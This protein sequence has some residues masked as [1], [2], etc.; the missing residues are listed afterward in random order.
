MV[1]RHHEGTFEK[2]LIAQCIS[3]SSV[4]GMRRWRSSLGDVGNF[5]SLADVGVGIRVLTVKRS[6]HPPNCLVNPVSRF[7][8]VRPGV[9]V[10]SLMCG[11]VPTEGLQSACGCD[12]GEY[13]VVNVEVLL[14][15][16]L[17]E[18]ELSSVSAGYAAVA[19]LP[20]ANRRRNK[21]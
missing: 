19:G 13:E 3:I 6:L 18:A 16:T 17:Q 21:L 5:C 15:G 7:L 14:T 11:E 9:Y 4:V 1:R 2:N 8:S 12:D 10:V 20:Q